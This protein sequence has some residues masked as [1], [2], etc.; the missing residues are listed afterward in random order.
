MA[1]ERPRCEEVHPQT[2]ERCTRLAGHPAF[3]VAGDHLDPE[4]TVW[5]SSQPLPDRIQKMTFLRRDPETGEVWTVCGDLSCP[6]MEFDPDSPSAV[7]ELPEGHAG[8]H[9]DGSSSW[10][11]E[12][13][14]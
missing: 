2:G 4:T 9:S 12:S 3:H 10:S 6:E 11:R 7:C 13:E 14:D 8:M 1:D 5:G